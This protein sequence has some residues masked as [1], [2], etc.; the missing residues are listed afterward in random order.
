MLI[1]RRH[2]WKAAVAVAGVPPQ[3]AGTQTVLYTMLLGICGE[4]WPDAAA[5][6]T[7][8]VGIH[9][10]SHQLPNSSWHKMHT[11]RGQVMSHLSSSSCMSGMSSFSCTT[12][13]PGMIAGHSDRAVNTADRQ[14]GGSCNCCNLHACKHGRPQI[15]VRCA[16]T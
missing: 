6:V 15:A 3:K 11:P 13:C 4:C 14:P 7:A 5:A 12:N 10:S 9:G 1:C 8:S 16:V 2:S